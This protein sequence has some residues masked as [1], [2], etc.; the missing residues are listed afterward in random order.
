MSNDPE[1][2]Q[3]MRAPKC[4]HCQSANTKWYDGMLGYEAIRC[5]DCHIETD[6]NK[7]ES[8]GPF[9]C[10]LHGVRLPDQNVRPMLGQD[11]TEA[12]RMTYAGRPIR[13]LKESKIF[14]KAKLE[15]SPLFEPTKPKLF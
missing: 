13:L 2:L 9:D 6:A 14:D 3:P 15:N 4:P 7:P 5:H 11:A 12:Q 10:P 8:F 1:I